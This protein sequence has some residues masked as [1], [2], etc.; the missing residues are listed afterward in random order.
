MD[1][2]YYKKYEPFFGTWY[3]DGDKSQLGTGSFAS[4]FRIVRH[5]ANVNPC[6][7]KIITIPKSD[8][9]IATLLHPLSSDIS[10]NSFLI[11]STICW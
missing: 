2:N 10:S 5:D 8:A 11:S 9:E 4:V 3:F 7:L 6:A 1:I